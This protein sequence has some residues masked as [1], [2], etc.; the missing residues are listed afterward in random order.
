MSHALGADNR[1]F[2][3]GSLLP[4]Y[5]HTCRTRVRNINKTKL[6]KNK[7]LDKLWKAK[8]ITGDCRSI[9]KFLTSTSTTR[10]SLALL[11]AV[12]LFPGNFRPARLARMFCLTSQP[13]LLR[14]RLASTTLMRSVSGHT[15]PRLPTPVQKKHSLIKHR[16]PVRSMNN[17]NDNENENKKQ[18]KR[19]PQCIILYRGQSP[20]QA[21]FVYLVAVLDF[22]EKSKRRV[23]CH[24]L[25]RSTRLHIRNRLDSQVA[26]Y[27]FYKLA[28]ASISH[29]PPHLCPEAAGGVGG[30]HQLDRTIAVWKRNIN[31]TNLGKSVG[32]NDFLLCRCF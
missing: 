29:N 1:P 20:N 2:F 23:C 5:V 30:K 15:T 27:W 26:S 25:W 11:L 6:Q 24:S 13:L 31:K 4:G 8:I 17:K 10:I 18:T 9:A 12:L 14:H 19:S 21:V 3:F 16:L 7:N 32:S 28:A 22:S